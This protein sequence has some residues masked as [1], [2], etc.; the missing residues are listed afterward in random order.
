MLLCRWRQYVSD[1]LLSSKYADQAEMVEERERTKA[2]LQTARMFP[3]FRSGEDG[4]MVRLCTLQDRP[5]I[6]DSP[7]PCDRFLS[8]AAAAAAPG[9]SSAPSLNFLIFADFAKG[10]LSTECSPH[11]GTDALAWKEYGLRRLSQVCERRLLVE[12]E[13]AAAASRDRNDLEL[14]PLLHRLVRF[15]QRFL[16]NA[17]PAAHT[18]L[19]E[20][21]TAR[22]LQSYSVVCCAR[23]DEEWVVEGVA[24]EAGH[25]AVMHESETMRLLVHARDLKLEQKTC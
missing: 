16:F 18:A 22:T 17:H 21:D 8:S 7:L 1:H 24:S 15:M 9:A 3:C 10:T 20:A 25:C 12:E 4:A 5:I 23:L 19:Q 13:P 2:F 11:E 14:Q 6:N